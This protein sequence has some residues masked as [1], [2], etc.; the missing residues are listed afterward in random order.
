MTSRHHRI[1]INSNTLKIS[2]GHVAHHIVCDELVTL[3]KLI[4]ETMHM[5]L[6]FV[7]SVVHSVHPIETLPL[8]GIDRGHKVREKVQQ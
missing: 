5:L 3:L 8:V 6:P 7:Q 1:T 4:P 2:H